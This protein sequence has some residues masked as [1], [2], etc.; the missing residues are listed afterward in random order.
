M[1][2]SATSFIAIALITRV[3]IADVLERILER[4]A[5]HDR[6]EHADVVARRPVHALRGGGQAAEDVAATDHDPDLDAATVD[7]GDLAGDER[8]ELGID[9]VR[10]VTEQRLAGQLEED[11]LVAKP[12]PVLPRAVRWPSLTAPPRARNG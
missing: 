11:P 1:Y 7:L 10:A 9:A 8:A 12:V 4:E 3:G 2:G 5:V 6:R